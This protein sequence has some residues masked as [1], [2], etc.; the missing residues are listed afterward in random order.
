ML[1]WPKGVL[2]A[3]M[4]ELSPLSA[5][6]PPRPPASVPP[7]RF[8]SPCLPLR[9]VRNRLADAAAFCAIRAAGVARDLSLDDDTDAQTESNCDGD[10]NDRGRTSAIV[11]RMTFT[12]SSAITRSMTSAL[13]ALVKRV[14]KLSDQVVGSTG[15]SSLR[16]TLG[17]CSCPYAK[18]AANSLGRDGGYGVKDSP[19]SLPGRMGGYNLGQALA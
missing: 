10:G 5:L 16:I 12:I 17:V 7:P 14:R 15:R 19:G 1:Q 13:H 2:M 11:E 8:R 6:P 9:P 4:G 3:G 18:G